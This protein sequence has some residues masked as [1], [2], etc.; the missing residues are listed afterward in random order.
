MGLA[1]ARTACVNVRVI[2]GACAGATRRR[3]R[4][5]L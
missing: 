5:G 1:R 4:A 2:A 3:A